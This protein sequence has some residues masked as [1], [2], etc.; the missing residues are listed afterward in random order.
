MSREMLVFAAAGLY[1]Q[2][3]TPTLMGRR[4]GS[5]TCLKRT[6]VPAR[7]TV[8]DDVALTS[9]DDSTVAKPCAE[10]RRVKTAGQRCRLSSSVVWVVPCDTS[11]IRLVGVGG[12][13]D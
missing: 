1:S 2:A 10:D 6:L 5:R 12:W 9:T 7:V 8:I 11:W 13:W 3:T 4:S